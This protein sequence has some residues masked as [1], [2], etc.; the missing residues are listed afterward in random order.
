MLLKDS[1]VKID[2]S[3]KD[4]IE[5]TNENMTNNENLRLTLWKNTLSL[6]FQKEDI[7]PSIKYLNNC[8]EII[9]SDLVEDKIA[10]FKIEGVSHSGVHRSILEMLVG[11]QFGLG[12]KYALSEKTYALIAL[13]GCH[14]NTYRDFQSLLVDLN[15]GS[16]DESKILFKLENL[17]SKLASE[18]A[19]GLGIEEGQ[20]VYR[21]YSPAFH[22]IR[23]KQ[24]LLFKEKLA[25]TSADKRSMFNE[26]RELFGKELALPPYLKIDILGYLDIP[27]I[28]EAFKLSLANA[29]EQQRQN[30]ERI[31]S[32]QPIP[33]FGGFQDP[34]LPNLYLFTPSQIESFL[35]PF[36]NLVAQKTGLA[37]NLQWYTDDIIRSIYSDEEILLQSNEA[38]RHIGNIRSFSRQFPFATPELQNL[39]NQKSGFVPGAEMWHRTEW[40]STQDKKKFTLHFDIVA[41][42]EGG[43][44]LQA[45]IE[46]TLNLT[47]FGNLQHDQREAIFTFIRMYANSKDIDK[48]KMLELLSEFQ[49]TGKWKD[50]P[51]ITS[52]QSYLAPLF[53]KV[54]QIDRMLFCQKLSQI[55]IKFTDNMNNKLYVAISSLG[56]PKSS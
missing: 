49:Q 22:E 41:E 48:P 47:S 2:Q 3:I 25:V 39:L 35:G 38:S 37:I 27:V 10:N 45:G 30:Q 9:H 33:L 21:N 16:I 46:E 40:S 18:E 20:A 12:K 17:I 44:I 14:P 54:N 4:V 43:G 36:L 28:F 6:D 5:I 23:E 19:K 55:T 31:N 53:A 51:E 7:H 24:E 1:I 11:V 34:L 56:V 29:K 15:S 50:H 8:I 52:L 42:K 32:N 26:I 13:T